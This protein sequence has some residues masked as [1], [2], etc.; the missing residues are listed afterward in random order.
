M[1]L[2]GVRDC[3]HIRVDIADVSSRVMDVQLH[4]Q[5]SLQLR[6]SLIRTRIEA[7]RAYSRTDALRYFCGVK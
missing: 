5:L 7:E 3:S 4:V 6:A 1:S 2:R